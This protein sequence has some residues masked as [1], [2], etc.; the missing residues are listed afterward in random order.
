[1]QAHLQSEIH[2]QSCATEADAATSVKGGSITQLIQSVR[3]QQKMKNR[4]A[5]KVLLRCTHFLT[6][7]HIAHTT[8]FEE[9][10]HLIESCG[11]EYLKAFSESSGKNV[12][13]R[14][15]DSVLGF[16]EALDSWVEWSLLKQVQ[17]AHFYN[18]MAD[19]CTDITTIKKLSIFCRWVEDGVPVEHFF[20]IV[21]IKK[22]ML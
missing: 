22:L 8:N 10:V 20:G 2:I 1:M 17:Q 19:E 12:T 9:L 16:V 13:Y 3:D 5:I 21:P 7:R 11:S 4:M 15:K 18:I 6:R 14:S